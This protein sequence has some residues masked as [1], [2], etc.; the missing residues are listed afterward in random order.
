MLVYVD[1]ILIA[2]NR[3]DSIV[4]LKQLLNAHF[5][6]KDLG[7]LR[8][9]LRIDVTQSTEGILLCQ[10]KYA[11]GIL[12]DLGTLASKPMKIPMDQNVKLSKEDGT[13]LPDPSSYRRLIGR[14][15]YLTITR[16][17][18]SY[19]VQTLN[20]FMNCPT[21]AYLAAAYKVLRYIKSAPGQGIFLST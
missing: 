2:S 21:T 4:A 6:I 18:I 20:Q 16:L 19:T 17:D 3:S 15:M 9:F 11:L 12:S 5:K 13:P 8:Y 10:R 1:D 14:L 7:A